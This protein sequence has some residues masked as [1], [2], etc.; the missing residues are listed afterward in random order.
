MRLKAY[1][2]SRCGLLS[3]CDGL[4][5]CNLGYI[6]VCVADCSQTVMN[7]TRVSG[8]IDELVQKTHEP[9]LPRLMNGE[10]VV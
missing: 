9:L 4:H 3:N 8:G 10:L 1:H 2:K 5:S 6:T 7:Y